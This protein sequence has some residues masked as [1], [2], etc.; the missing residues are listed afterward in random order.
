MVMNFNYFILFFFNYRNFVRIIFIKTDIKN[1]CC[2]ILFI[3]AHFSLYCKIT[4]ILLLVNIKMSSTIVQMLV[5]F[6]V[7]V[8]YC[9]YYEKMVILLRKL[10]Y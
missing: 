5:F 10:Y 4:F 1:T 3:K 2:D 7:T 9:N 8:Y 6:N